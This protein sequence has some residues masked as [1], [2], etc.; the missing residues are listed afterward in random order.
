[1]EMVVAGVRKAVLGSG[2]GGCGARLPSLPPTRAAGCDT[3]WR[4]VGEGR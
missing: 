3:R 1:M 2:H 4:L